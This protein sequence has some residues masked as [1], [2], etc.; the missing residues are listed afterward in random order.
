MLRAIAFTRILRVPT[1]ASQAKLLPVRTSRDEFLYDGY[2][3]V[4]ANVGIVSNV[5]N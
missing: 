3:Q 2:D 4:Q 1:T 5:E